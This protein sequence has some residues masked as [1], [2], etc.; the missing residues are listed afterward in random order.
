MADARGFFQYSQMPDKFY[1]R[2][3]PL[4]FTEVRSFAQMIF[5]AHPIQ[6]GANQGV[7]NYVPDPN[8]PT[9]SQICLIYA[10][11]V[12]NTVMP[13]YPYPTGT[14]RKALKVNLDFFY[15]SFVDQGCTQVFPYGK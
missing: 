10:S 2:D 3:R 15:S 1:R 12:Y 9:L 8:S 13:L 11:F 5:D 7:A 4:M 14:L 6:L